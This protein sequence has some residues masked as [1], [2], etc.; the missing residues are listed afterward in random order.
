MN[1]CRLIYVKFH[2]FDRLVNRPITNDLFGSIQIS[3]SCNS[4]NYHNTSRARPQVA[5]NGRLV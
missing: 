5:Y 2:Q 4:N 3:S 1:R